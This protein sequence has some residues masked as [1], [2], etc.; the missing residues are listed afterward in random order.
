[1]RFMSSS[2]LNESQILDLT[3]PQTVFELGFEEKELLSSSGAKIIADI[4]DRARDADYTHMYFRDPMRPGIVWF[5]ELDPNEM[6]LPTRAK[7]EEARLI[8]EKVFPKFLISIQSEDIDII[9]TAIPPIQ[10]GVGGIEL[11]TALEYIVFLYPEM[12][13]AWAAL[14]FCYRE[15]LNLKSSSNEV[16]QECISKCQN[17]Q[18]VSFMMESFNEV[19]T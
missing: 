16:Y 10:L 12:V 11:A 6:Q 9:M 13:R 4:K 15:L 5:T 14:I 18:V 19:I 1:M 8:T 2:Y 3:N 17:A 7:L